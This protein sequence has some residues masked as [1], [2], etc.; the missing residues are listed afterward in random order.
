[1][2]QSF[3]RLLVIVFLGCCLMPVILAIGQVSGNDILSLGFLVEQALLTCS[4]LIL[5]VAFQNQEIF[6]IT[7]ERIAPEIK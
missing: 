5:T 3:L 7:N 1:M 2:M 6:A 4:G